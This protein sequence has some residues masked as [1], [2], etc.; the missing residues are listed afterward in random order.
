MFDTQSCIFWFSCKLTEGMRSIKD[1]MG[2]F[3]I[4]DKVIM[5]SIFITSIGLV[6]LGQAQ[7]GYHGLFIELIGL[8]LLILDIYLYN[9]KFR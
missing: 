6:V 2:R 1:S 7:V 8:V 5:S 9:R 3:S 4:L